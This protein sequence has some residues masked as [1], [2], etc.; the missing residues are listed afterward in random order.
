MM[1]KIFP[2]FLPDFEGKIAGFSGFLT[3]ASGN[4]ASISF[5]FD[6]TNNS[7]KTNRTNHITSQLFSYPQVWSLYI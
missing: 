3:V 2:D 5:F 4:P 6:Q 7:I 1:L